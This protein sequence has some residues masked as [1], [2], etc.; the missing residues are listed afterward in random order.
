MKTRL[1]TASVSVLALATLSA[2]VNKADD[3]P[4]A[5]V[6]VPPPTAETS[7]PTVADARAFL[8]RADFKTIV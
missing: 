8:E 4:P 5:D 3:L 6:P 1:I 7:G 2:C